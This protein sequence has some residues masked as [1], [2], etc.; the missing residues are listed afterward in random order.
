MSDL[1]SHKTSIASL[2]AAIEPFA[3]FAQ[4][5]SFD[6]LP[7]NTPMTRGS[8]LAKSQ[9]TAGDFIRALDVLKKINAVL[10][11]ELRI[12]EIDGWF[13]EAT[14][15]GS[16]MAEAANE[17]EQLV[18]TLRKEGYQIEHKHQARSGTGGRVD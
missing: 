6:K 17:R 3:K 18:N 1:I 11:A 9:V 16:W 8:P 14:G 13:A 5:S 12:A 7:L 15:W 10:L 4:A 2:L